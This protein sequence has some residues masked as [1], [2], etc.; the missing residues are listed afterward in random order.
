MVNAAP[1]WFSLMV[2]CKID[3][4]LNRFPVKSKF[5]DPILNQDFDLV[6]KTVF[7]L[8]GAGLI[9]AFEPQLFKILPR[10]IADR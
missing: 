9:V 10:Q 8:L 5:L 7:R 4:K 3:V 6:L 2:Q 1:G